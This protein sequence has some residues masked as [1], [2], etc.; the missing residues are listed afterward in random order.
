[1]DFINEAKNYAEQE[2][3]LAD[4]LLALDIELNQ[5]IVASENVSSWI[6][7]NYPDGLGADNI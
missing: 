3:R 2:Q 4:T 5:P 6:G 1:M 7:I